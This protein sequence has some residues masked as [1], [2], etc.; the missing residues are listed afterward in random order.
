MLKKFDVKKI[1][2]TVTRLFLGMRLECAECHSHPLENLTQDDFYGVAAFFARRNVKRGYGEYRRTWDLDDEGEALH[3]VTTKPVAARFLA[4]S[5]PSIPPG[6]DRR[7]VLAKW[8]TSREN[9]NFA[10]A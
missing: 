1:T 6:E 2:P 10:R 7:N 4:A 3:P 9:P 5:E 8:I